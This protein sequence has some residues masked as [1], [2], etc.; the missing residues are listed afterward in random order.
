VSLTI[1]DLLN[2]HD[3]SATRASTVHTL[4]LTFSETEY[5]PFMRQV[6]VLGAAL[7][8]SSPDDT[9]KLVLQRA[10]A[11]WLAAQTDR[12]PVHPTVP[13]LDAAAAF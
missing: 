10:Y 4:K 13:R 8:S 12:S 11:H 1:S 9:L 7:F 6:D 3:Q 2:R 5:E